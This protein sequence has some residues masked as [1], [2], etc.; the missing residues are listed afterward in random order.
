VRGRIPSRTEP[1]RKPT[2][3]KVSRQEDFEKFSANN[4]RTWWEPEGNNAPRE[5]WSKKT[6]IP[7]E[8]YMIQRTPRGHTFYVEDT[9]TK[10]KV[11]LIDRTGMMFKM[12]A[13]VLAEDEDG[14][15]LNDYNMARRRDENAEQSTQLSLSKIVGNT[16]KI[17]LIDLSKQ[18]LEFLATSLSEDDAPDGNRVLLS[19]VGGFLRIRERGGKN[20]GG[21]S[22]GEIRLE[23]SQKAIEI[24]DYGFN[25]TDNNE[26]IG[27]KNDT[28]D[29]HDGKGLWEHQKR[30]TIKVG[31]NSYIIIEPTSITI[32]SGT[33]NITADADV[34]I[35]AGGNVNVRGTKINLN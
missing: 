32:R 2:D 29:M 34:N 20:N 12:D 11:V 17:L 25:L 22:K 23:T 14:E 5:T 13:G 19:G 6:D 33:I 10:E 26:H 9:P 18:R 7:P 35:T 31:Q 15:P 1:V 30:I 28:F 4:T 16:G 24:M 8:I 3:D 21:A 27:G